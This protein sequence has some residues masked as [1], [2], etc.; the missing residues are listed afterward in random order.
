MELPPYS[1]HSSWASR[2]C[3]G[4]LVTKTKCRKACSFCGG[5]VCWLPFHKNR[6][7]QQAWMYPSQA[8]ARNTRTAH[9][10]TAALGIVQQ[11]V[12]NISHNKAMCMGSDSIPAL[13]SPIFFTEPRLLCS[14]SV[15]FHF[16]S[17]W[18]HHKCA[19]CLCGPMHFEG[20]SPQ[21]ATMHTL[22]FPS[23]SRYFC[24]PWKGM[25]ISL[26]VIGENMSS[27]KD[28]LMTDWC[29]STAKAKHIKCIALYL[30]PPTYPI[31]F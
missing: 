28:K 30:C 3:V 15:P 2:C 6:T 22:I 16:L 1:S 4:L 5:N 27:S 17:L 12:K 24:C 31:I 29:I 18:H 8:A 19:C 7:V 13:Y 21:T 14:L 10:E 23:N 25:K 11:R 26:A 20:H 9:K